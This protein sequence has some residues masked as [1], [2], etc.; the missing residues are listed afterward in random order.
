MEVKWTYLNPYRFSSGHVKDRSTKF[1]ARISKYEKEI[2]FGDDPLDYALYFDHEKDEDCRAY[3]FSR[4]RQ[5]RLA[6]N[7]GRFFNPSIVLLGEGYSLYS[8]RFDTFRTTSETEE[9]RPGNNE[10][11]CQIPREDW[12]K[13]KSFFW[14]DWNTEHR[15]PYFAA[16]VTILLIKDPQG[17]FILPFV[18]NNYDFYRFRLSGDRRLVQIDG[19]IYIHS[20]NMEEMWELRIH[21]QAHE[22]WHISPTQIFDLSENDEDYPHLNGYN[23]Q[24]T[25]LGQS[26]KILS[27]EAGLKRKREGG[28]E[29]GPKEPPKPR[30]KRF[31]DREFTIIDWFYK[32][33]L[34]YVFVKHDK[35]FRTQ[36]KWPASL[37]VLGKGSYADTRPVSVPE[38]EEE[39]RSGSEKG[40]DAKKKKIAEPPSSANLYR[41][42]PISFSTPHINIGT[43]DKPVLL[44]VG[45]LK[46]PTN[47]K[48]FTFE[49]DSVAYQVQQNLPKQ[50][51]KCF[52]DR[53]VEH[54]GSIPLNLDK[55]EKQAC[56]GYHYFLYFY[57]LSEHNSTD[58]PG[59]FSRFEL[60]DPI[61]PFD[62]T[63]IKPENQYLPNDIE[64][65]GKWR[66]SLVFPTG[67]ALNGN[68]IVVTCGVGDYYSI[69][70]KFRK[71]QVLSQLNHDL[72][73]LNVDLL[74]YSV[75]PCKPQEELENQPRTHVLF[76]ATHEW[77]C[78]EYMLTKA[79]IPGITSK[80]I[81]VKNNVKQ[82][83][84]F[85]HE[86]QE[87]VCPHTLD[88]LK[89]LYWLTELA[90]GK[91]KAS[92]CYKCK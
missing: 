65:Q 29:E 70:L 45:H 58:A 44:G 10:E 63:R 11:I 20:P 60:S 9:V 66:F 21:H 79:L 5:F 49:E 83:C 52:G 8:F 43:G 88:Y 64:T 84:F 61:L 27:I 25:Y 62:D 7:R 28:E 85:V 14:N 6:K 89:C 17:N 51:K 2:H 87:K 37:A 78:P 90:L 15:N 73:N 74:R 54:F 72:F 26:E 40:V 56:S 16:T 67:L 76:D 91:R 34:Q 35:E 19:A 3:L 75:L 4:R 69:D 30:T 24:L 71:E 23:L 68:T 1:S 92:I 42:P 57:R 12:A 13:G 59:V 80:I 47:Q 53:Y 55:K 32:E 86:N 48:N 77:H 22:A 33:G 36:K 31:P 18:E 81:L 50:F 82:K 41:S 46:I 39:M 38:N